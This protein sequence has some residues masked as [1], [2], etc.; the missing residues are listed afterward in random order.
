MTNGFLLELEAVRGEA[1][2]W[3]PTPLPIP[4]MVQVPM[5]R[6]RSQQEIVQQLFPQLMRQ[7]R[8]CSRS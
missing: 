7:F 5:Y 4:S 8:A 3:I 6:A 1:A 2:T